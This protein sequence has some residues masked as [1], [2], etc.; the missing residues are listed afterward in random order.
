MVFL[1]WCGGVFVVVVWWCQHPARE[2]AFPWYH[3]AFLLAMHVYR[4]DQLRICALIPHGPKDKKDT[5][6]HDRQTQHCIFKVFLQERFVSAE[7][8]H[9]TDTKA[10]THTVVH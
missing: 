10:D 6:R 2:P 1:W 7:C 5:S 4:G 3:D 9:G 8:I